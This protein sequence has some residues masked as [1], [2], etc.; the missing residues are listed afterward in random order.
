MA[1]EVDEDVDEG[2]YIS[3]ELRVGGKYRL[4]HKIG[5]GGFSMLPPQHRKY[6]TLIV[7]LVR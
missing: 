7:I 2:E 1:D 5:S 3:L 4:C 6:T